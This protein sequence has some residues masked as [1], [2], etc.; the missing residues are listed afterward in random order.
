[1]Q[2]NPFEI[3]DTLSPHDTHTAGTFPVAQMTQ[4][5]PRRIQNSGMEDESREQSQTSSTAIGTLNCPKSGQDRDGMG[6]GGDRR[7]LAVQQ[8]LEDR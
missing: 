6:W 5:G 1:M 8:L 3:S 7:M 4:T 2:H